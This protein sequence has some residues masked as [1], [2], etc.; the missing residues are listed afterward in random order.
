MRSLRAALPRIRQINRCELYLPA[1]G[2]LDRYP[3]LRPALTNPIRW[4]LIERNYDLMLRYATAIRQ[5]TPSTEAI[6]RRFNSDVTHP[7]YAAMLETGRAQRTLFIALMWNLGPRSSRCSLPR[8]R[9]SGP[10]IGG[11]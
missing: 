1:A 8:G 5:G 6:L 4:E 9:L 7:A 2:D 10:E 3:R 11:L